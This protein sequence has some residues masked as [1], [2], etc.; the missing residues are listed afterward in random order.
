MDNTT[1]TLQQVETSYADGH[2]TA[3]AV[4]SDLHGLEFAFDLLRNNAERVAQRWYTKSPERSFAVDAPG[5]YRVKCFARAENR[6][7]QISKSVP[8]FVRPVGVLPDG[9][10]AVNPA[11]QALELIAERWRFPALFFPKLGGRLFVLLP[12]AVSASASRPSFSRWTWRDLFPGDVLCIADPTLDLHAQLK[13]GW[14]IGHRDNCA[15]E[16]LVPFIVNYARARG[17]PNRNIVFWGSSAGGF[18]ALALAARIEGSVAVAINAQTDA[19]SYQVTH[20]V[21]LVRQ[22]CFDD[23]AEAEI[24]T[25]Y[26]A[27]VNMIAAWADCRSRAFLVQNTLDKHHHEVHFRPLWESFGGEVGEGISNAGPHVAWVYRDERG[28]APESEQMAAQLIRLA[29]TAP[30]VGPWAPMAEPASPAM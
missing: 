30:D 3:K 16:A 23:M 29:L 18:A 1:G 22:A 15:T 17:I 5:Y 6:E 28:H 27:R 19:L 20:Q 25:A 14:M 12:S 7:L 24:R 11:A 4:C 9:L 2:I 10:A 21:Q 26:P 8:L 13:L